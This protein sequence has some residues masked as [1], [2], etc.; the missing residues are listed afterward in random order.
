MKRITHQAI[1][2][3]IRA[4]IT[5]HE[6]ALGERIPSEAEFAQEY[7]CSRTT[8]NRA[9]Q[10]LADEGLVERKRKGG[11]RVRPVPAPYAE[12]RLPVFREQVESRGH[13]YS[14]EILVREN[15]RP[16]AAIA[17]RLGVGAMEE[18]AYLETLHRADDAPFAFE[19]RWVSL[20]AVPGFEKADLS[21]TSANEFL[22][23]SVPFTRGHV[24]LS[25]AAVRG[26]CARTLGVADDTAVLAMERST[27]TGDLPVTFVRIYFAQGHAFDF[28]V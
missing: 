22:V 26:P 6:W 2:E 27:W 15:R 1:R 11:T 20:A 23:R 24:T 3:A 14:F 8:V 28:D 21:S 17:A 19:R 18:C 9:L 25:A 4:R 10:A 5:G 7:G 16:A 13:A 12:F